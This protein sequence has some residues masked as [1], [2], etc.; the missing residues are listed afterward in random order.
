[1]E[2]PEMNSKGSD[3]ILYEL[4]GNVALI[5][6]NRPDVI[7]AINDAIREGLQQ[8][9]ARADE[10]ER[11]RTIVIHGGNARGFCVGADIKE[12]REP[13]S[14]IALRQRQKRS[15]WL[16]AFDR[17]TKPS[18][19]AIHG[20]CHGGGMEMALA[21]D[22]RIAANDAVFSLPETGL[23]LI[24]GAGGTQRLPR[25]VGM[26]RALDI[27]LTGRRINAGEALEI[28][29]LS[30]I[31]GEND[32]VLKAALEMAD[33]IASRAPAA[34]MLAR[35]AVHQGMDLPLSAGLALERNLF[36]MLSTTS[37]RIEAANA[38]REKRKPVFVGE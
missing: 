19:A 29:L 12:H 16:D 20:H 15:F 18:I 8:L 24:P 6:L 5:T 9:L 1:M 14:A 31:V 38:F 33:Q 27:I 35:E 21:C 11:V 36:A 7:N 22:I 26:G 10:D 28:G 32:N 4:R 17:F 2:R 34:T 30:R 3:A 23:G 25:I 13:E 37:D